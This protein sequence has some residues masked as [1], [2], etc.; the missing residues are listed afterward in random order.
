[1]AIDL[2]QA[3][4]F[5]D[6]DP[7]K[8]YTKIV[9]MPGR[10]SQ[11][12]EFTQA[13]DIQEDYL[14]RL[15]NAVLKNGEILSGCVLAISDDNKN[16]MLSSGQIFLDGLVRNVSDQT[17]KIKGEGT[18]SIGIVIEE[19]LITETDDNSLYDNAEGYRNY[20][21]SGAHRIKQEPVWKVD[22]PSAVSIYQLVDGQIV[23]AASDSSDDTMSQITE[24]LAR[25][26]FDENGSYKVNGLKIIDRN[27]ND[28]ENVYVTVQEGKAY[29]AGYE[30]NKEAS[31]RIA[32]KK[33]TNVRTQY[34]E[35]KKFTS[36]I[37][38]PLDNY[39]VNRIE[40][41][42]CMV[43]KS[44]QMTRGDISGGF[45]LIEEKRAGSIT[46]IV[47]ISAGDT[48]Y[49]PITDYVFQEGGISWEPTGGK[50]PG[51]GTTYN[52]EYMFNQKMLPNEFKVSH[53]KIYHSPTTYTLTRGRE[54]T[55]SLPIAAGIK[56]V[57][58]SKVYKASKTYANN[59]DWKLSGSPGSYAI[60]WTSA[61]EKPEGEYKVDLV[62]LLTVVDNDRDYLEFTSPETPI[63]LD[64]Q[65]VMDYTYYLARTDLIIMN[66][67]TVCE[68]IEGQPDVLR[69]VF[70]PT[71]TNSRVLPLGTVLVYPNSTKIIVTNFNN[72]RLEQSQLYNM[73]Q[74]VDNLEYNVALS[75]LDTEAMEG[76]NAT[77]LKGI[78]TDG[79]IG[80]TKADVSN[81]GFDCSFDFDYGF[82][83]LPQNE[84]I[85]G[86]KPNSNGSASLLG[87][88][89]SAPYTDV[90]MVEQ[91]SATDEFLVNPYDVYSNLAIV[92]IDPYVDNWVDTERLTVDAGTTYDSRTEDVNG[93]TSYVNGG[94]TRRTVTR[95]GFFADY[96]EVS[97][98]STTDYRTSTSSRTEES[99]RTQSD[100]ILDEAIEYMRPIEIIV[101]GS[102]FTLNTDDLTCYIDDTKVD[103]TPIGDTQPG[104]TEGTVKSN[105]EGK[106]NAKFTIPEGIPCG[107]VE[108]KVVNAYNEGGTRFSA[109]G[110]RQIIQDSVFRTVTTV[111]TR[112]TTAVVTQYT[113]I[114]TIH[115]PLAQS[116]YVDKDYVLTK[117]G[118]FF[119]AKDN[120]KNIIIEIRELNNGYPSATILH[121]QVV[122][123]NDITVDPEGQIETTIN[124]SQPVYLEGN[125]SYCFVIVS[126]SPK[127]AMWTAKLGGVDEHSY[128]EAYQVV[129]Q[130]YTEG[131]LFSSS[132]AQTWTAHQDQ[133]LKFKLYRARFSDTG[134]VLYPDATTNDATALVL[135]AQTAD[136]ENQGVDWYYK[137]VTDTNDEHNAWMPIETFNYL[138]LGRSLKKVALKCELH[139]KS[140]NI[141][142]FLNAE[143]VNLVYY[144]NASTGAYVSR[145]VVMEQDFNTIQLS[146]EA[147]R[148][149][150]TDFKIYYTTADNDG[151]W[152]QLT[153]PQQ[154][155][156][157]QNFTRYTYTKSGLPVG[158]N[159]C[160][161]KIE[162]TSSDILSTPIIRRLMTIMKNV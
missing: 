19:E 125:K 25:R 47:K 121:Q 102:N 42:N 93:G 119:S 162:L 92:E 88:I 70:P 160:R 106:F 91:L 60:D 43:K 110:R 20:G 141:S 135:A 74:R 66:P 117:L 142:P 131:V 159:K 69:R 140:D 95:G 46:S 63:V 98:S 130:P 56:I 16:A 76:E 24:I 155:Q 3:P 1:M 123:S 36:D 54:N 15:G 33:A 38:Y 115:D 45:D 148:P 80:P 133:D 26:T 87:G 84:G 29:I 62:L 79:F 8:N 153:D 124:L 120:T 49:E 7:T 127:Y 4:Y 31:S 23:A 73:R 116:F 77:Q 86:M 94:T 144:N 35:T 114:T 149:D 157:D 82:L 21:N 11:V 41:L 78:F 32:I 147:Y 39:P 48:T 161:I 85:V 152:Q 59:T 122:D 55:D 100:I 134:T 10:V 37:T 57:N 103:L 136:Y 81:D 101:H 158:T 72:Y 118:L 128:D 132:N 151:G 6:Y 150:K 112:T 13:Q 156:V 97:H 108:V 104:S 12:R 138:E 53:N 30:A 52:V 67:N 28:K 75:D 89:A 27:T 107:T 58:I 137:E 139:T 129:T 34:N 51:T 40:D 44:V 109:Q 2:T 17:V 18:E 143:S 50:E 5:D 68:V 154:V 96:D 83:M 14:Q 146:V 65:I 22:D 61:S 105:V 99:F 9:G 90:V 126:D 113:T 145:Q 71:N 64:S 111:T